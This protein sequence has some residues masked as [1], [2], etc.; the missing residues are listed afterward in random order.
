[1]NERA[2]YQ[3]NYY[4]AHKSQV[5]M[6]RKE[7]Y[8]HDEDYRARCRQRDRA[9]YLNIKRWGGLHSIDTDLFC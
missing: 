5:L 1:M 9:R 4:L 6:S 2:E 7:R 3:H 8:E